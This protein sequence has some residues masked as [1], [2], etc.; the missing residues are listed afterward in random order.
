MTFLSVSGHH[1]TVLGYHSP[2]SPLL[3]AVKFREMLAK[4]L[5]RLQESPIFLDQRLGQRANRDDF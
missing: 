5:R 3:D 1:K 4:P 2:M